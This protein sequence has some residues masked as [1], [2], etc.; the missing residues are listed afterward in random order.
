MAVSEELHKKLDEIF[1]DDECISH[2]Y[3]Q[4]VSICLQALVA[5]KFKKG[6]MSEEEYQKWSLKPPAIKLLEPYGITYQQYNALL[7][8]KGTSKTFVTFIRVMERHGFHFWRLFYSEKLI[9]LTLNTFK[10]R[11]SFQEKFN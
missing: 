5:D 9:D 1:S 3:H 8:G 6:E 7:A 10:V 2:F 4:I 11:K